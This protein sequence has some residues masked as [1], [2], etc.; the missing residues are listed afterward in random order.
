M[1]YGQLDVSEV[2]PAEYPLI[3][4]LRDTIFGDRPD[5]HPHSVEQTLA[6]RN[7]VLALIAHLEGNPVGYQIGYAESPT[8]YHLELAGVLADYR[9]QGLG[10]RMLDYHVGVARSRSYQRLTVGPFDPSRVP[11]ALPFALRRGFRQAGVTGDER[12]R[13]ERDLG[14]QAP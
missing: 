2:G 10:T 11:D 3:Q 4:V 1:G 8:T 12:V 7:D 13:L 9:R 6:G 5:L 14:P